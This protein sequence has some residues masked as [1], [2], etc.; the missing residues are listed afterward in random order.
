MAKSHV[1]KGDEVVVIS[2][3]AKGR[4][5]TVSKVLPAKNLVYLEG[6]D[7]KSKAQDDR[8]RLVKPTL[9]YMRKSQNNPEGGMLWLEGPVH[10]SNVM[11]ADV[12][13]ARRSKQSARS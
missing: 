3:S 8:E 13:E 12:F 10:I 11:K 1:K 7:E 5:G 6:T 2:G 9:H 4:R